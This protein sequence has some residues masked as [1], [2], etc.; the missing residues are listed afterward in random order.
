MVRT[1]TMGRERR[2]GVVLSV[3]L[4]AALVACVVLGGVAT[5]WF[6]SSGAPSRVAGVELVSS[7]TADS[8]DGKSGG[9]EKSDSD[10]KSDG[11]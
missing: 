10:K 5:A 11:G 4:R 9:D 7:S 8:P 2:C 1:F 6:L 3:V